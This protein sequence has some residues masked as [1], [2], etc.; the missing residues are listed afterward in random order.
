MAIAL[1][2]AFVLAAVA[3]YFAGARLVKHAVGE[4]S[5]VAVL[6]FADL[7]TEPFGAVFTQQLADQ[8]ARVEGLHVFTPPGIAG[9]RI[10]AVVEGTV[11]KSGDQLRINAQLVQVASRRRLWSHTYEFE[12]K[13]V[14]MIQ[15]E[16]VRAIVS[17]LRQPGSSQSPRR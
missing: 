10:G 2:A 1:I 7:G 5:Y 13:E 14:A 17:A 15:A 12:P 11:R 8:L 3:L 4:L 6:P 9:E 16:M